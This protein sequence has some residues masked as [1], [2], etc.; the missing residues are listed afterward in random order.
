VARILREAVPI[1]AALGWVVALVVMALVHRRRR[2]MADWLARTEMVE[3]RRYASAVAEGLAPR[4]ALGVTARAAWVVHRVS[5]LNTLVALAWLGI[6]AFVQLQVRAPLVLYPRPRGLVIEAVR[7]GGP[8]WNRLLARF[9]RW[10]VWQGYRLVNPQVLVFHRTPFSPVFWA[11]ARRESLVAIHG[12]LG[13]RTWHRGW[14]WT[15]FGYWVH[16]SAAEEMPPRDEAQAQRWEKSRREAYRGSYVHF[17]RALMHRRLRQE[18]FEILNPDAFAGLVR[19]GDHFVLLAWPELRVKVAGATAPS[20]LKLLHGYLRVDPSGRAGGAWGL[21][22]WSW[23][24][25]MPGTVLWRYAAEQDSLWGIPTDSIREV[26]A[27]E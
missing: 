21:D 5:A 24:E 17:L 6:A 20:R 25:A 9:E 22:G 19:Q 11:E 12:S 1:L 15:A 10:P 7:A 26:A 2:H 13:A 14:G 27:L 3:P 18:G 23:L 4:G 16:E 8:G